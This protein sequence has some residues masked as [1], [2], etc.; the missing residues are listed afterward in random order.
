MRSFKTVLASGLMLAAAA[1][2]GRAAPLTATD[3]LS[4]FNA[5]VSGSFTSN[6][7]VEGRLA[8]NAMVGGATFR[9]QLRGFAAPSAFQEINAVTIGSGVNA[10]VNNGGGVNW[11]TSNAGTFNLNGGG[12][13]R[14][15]A[16]AF[17]I[18]DFTTPLNALSAQVGGLAANSSVNASDPN[19]FTFNEVGGAGATAVFRVSAAQLSTARNLVFNGSAGTVIID[20]TG[21]GSFSA[22]QINFNATETQN[23]TILWN[24]GNETS[25]SFSGW[26]GT[27]LAPNAAV[28]NSSAMEGVLYAASFNGSG[29][30]HDFTFAGALPAATAVPEPG[31][32]AVL[33][34]ALGGLGLSRL[35]RRTRRAKLG[36]ATRW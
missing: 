14:R 16:P 26:H 4:Q 27:V 11:V 30:L 18:T 9:N 3:I 36:A 24:F 5:V 15:N 17:A 10:N 12:T 32:A 19:N 7:D 13:V 29:E 22:S 2:P 35:K 31:T 33:G 23:R 8:T 20:V 28:S 34:A 6:S 25:L 21:T 1:A